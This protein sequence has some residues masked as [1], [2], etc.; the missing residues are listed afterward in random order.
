MTPI[1]AIVREYLRMRRAN[2]FLRPATAW[3][4]ARLICSARAYAPLI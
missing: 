2:P 3:N 4:A 1:T